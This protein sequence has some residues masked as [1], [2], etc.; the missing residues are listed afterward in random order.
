MWSEVIKRSAKNIRVGEMMRKLKTSNNKKTVEK[1]Q[2]I[3][4]KYMTENHMPYMKLFGMTATIKKEIEVFEQ[5]GFY[6]TIKEM[7]VLFSKIKNDYERLMEYINSDKELT[8]HSFL[9]ADL[10][11]LHTKAMLHNKFTELC[12]LYKEERKEA[13]ESWE[14]NIPR[15]WDYFFH[16]LEVSA[17][18]LKDFAA[19]DYFP[20]DIKTICKRLG[21]NSRKYIDYINKSITGEDCIKMNEEQKEKLANWLL[22]GNEAV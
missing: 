2:A 5:S 22:E 17:Y 19:D 13:L 12:N 14:L 20:K 3:S 10:I 16:N 8:A 6:S 4:K 21:T 11:G 18:C 15:S 1:M 7:K 9:T